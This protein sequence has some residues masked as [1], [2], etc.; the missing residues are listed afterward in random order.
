VDLDPVFGTWT[1]HGSLF[2][3]EDLNWT[4]DFPNLQ[5]SDTYY[6]LLSA[7]VL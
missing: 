6:T 2:S 3:A 5:N 1:G 7:D 4:S